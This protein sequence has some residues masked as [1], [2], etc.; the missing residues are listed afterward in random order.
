MEIFVSIIR[1][2][3]LKIF[4]VIATML[5]IILIQ[6]DIMDIYIKSAFNQNVQLIYT[7][8]S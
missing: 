6:I 1:L 2:K 4:L 5:E 3:L 7:N 8:I